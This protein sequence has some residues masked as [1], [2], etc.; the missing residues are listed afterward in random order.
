MEAVL[1]LENGAW[2]RGLSAGA[3]GETSGEV[4]FNT[5]MTGYQEVLTDPSYAGQ[6]VTFGMKPT[7]PETGYG[8]IEAGAELPGAPGVQRVARFIEKP[9]AAKAADL[10]AGGRHLWNSGMFVATAATLVAE[11]ERHAPEVLRSVGLALAEATRDLDFVRLGAVAFTAA[12]AISTTRGE[13]T[14]P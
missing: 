7:A 1:A 3:S 10:V 4:V 2:F 8:Y 6:I 5:S 9:D 11:L 12:P 13:A 14:V